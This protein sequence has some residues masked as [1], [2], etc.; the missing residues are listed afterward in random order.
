M[1][2][3]MVMVVGAAAAGSAG[4]ATVAAAVARLHVAHGRGVARVDRQVGRQV[5]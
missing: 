5:T 1:V 4:G 2:V 3:V